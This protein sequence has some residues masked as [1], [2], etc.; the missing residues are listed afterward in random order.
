M[1]MGADYYQPLAERQSEDCNSS[2]RVP[3]G[4]GRDTIVRRAIIDKN[5]RIG[6]NVHIVNKDRVQEAERENLGFF[7]R[8]G[9]VVVLKNATIPDGTII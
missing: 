6:C 4:I 7:I 5:A 3:M 1:I 2:D 9:I 8:S